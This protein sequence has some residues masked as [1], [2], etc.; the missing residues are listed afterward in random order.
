MFFNRNKQDE[1][2]NIFQNINRPFIKVQRVFIIT[3][4]LATLGMNSV[5]ANEEENEKLKTEN[6]EL[7]EQNTETENRTQEEKLMKT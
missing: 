7:K 3:M 5:F 6:I 2:K 4:M 1:T